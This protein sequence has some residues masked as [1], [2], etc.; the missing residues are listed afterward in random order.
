LLS[1]IATL[2]ALA[3]LGCGLVGY[4]PPAAGDPDDDSPPDL[5]D[6]ATQSFAITTQGRAQGPRAAATDSGFAVAWTDDRDGD[7]RSYLRVFAANSQPET[8]EIVVGTSGSY[9]SPGLAWTGSE[10]AVLWREGGASSNPLWLSRYD[11]SG[12]V[13]GTPELITESATSNANPDLAAGDAGLGGAWPAFNVEITDPRELSAWFAPITAG[14]TRAGPGDIASWWG[15][16][17]CRPDV[18]W[19]GDHWGV[20][21]ANDGAPEQTGYGIGLARFDADGVLL[22]E[23]ENPVMLNPPGPSASGPSLAWSGEVYA[24]TWESQSLFVAI[25]TSEG[26]MLAGP[27][28]LGAVSTAT[29][30]WVAGRFLLVWS[31]DSGAPLAQWLTSSGELV[32]SPIR[33]GDSAGPSRWPSIATAGNRVWIVWQDDELMSP[34]LFVASSVPS[35]R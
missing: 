20:V 31:D 21:T 33:L 15:D 18:V 14:G 24:A 3:H 4:D 6:V 19:A 25:F 8:D 30:E 23:A 28:D 22:T 9:S 32:D 2:L 1:R 12:T 27:I 5:A 35:I 17:L 13:Q 10:L 26:E 16:C 34:R 7:Y 11:T 29:V